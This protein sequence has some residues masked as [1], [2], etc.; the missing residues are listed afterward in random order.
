MIMSMASV[1]RRLTGALE[2]GCIGREIGW[3]AHAALWRRAS[4]VGAHVMECGVSA[5]IDM[6]EKTTID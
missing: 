5:I 6:C 2:I 3:W 4:I 1:S